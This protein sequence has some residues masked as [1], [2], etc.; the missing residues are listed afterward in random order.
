VTPNDLILGDSAVIFCVENGKS[1]AFA[2]KDDEI[3]SVFLPLSPRRLVIG[4]SSNREFDIDRGL[5][6]QIARCSH[7]FLSQPNCLILTLRSRGRSVELP[8]RFRLNSV[9]KSLLK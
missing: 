1:K 5:R 4:T 7:N 3:Q 9:V 6:Q 2:D 8:S